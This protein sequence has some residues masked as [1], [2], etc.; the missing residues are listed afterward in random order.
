MSSQQ[1][2]QPP[3]NAP[4]IPSLTNNETFS[5][6]PKNNNEPHFANRV[7]GFISNLLRPTPT[8]TTSSSVSSAP[9]RTFAN[10]LELE[11]A[12]EEEEEEQITLPGTHSAN[13]F[14]PFDEST[15]VH[16]QP[17]ASIQRTASTINAGEVKV[18][19]SKEQL[20]RAHKY[21]SKAHRKTAE[22]SKWAD[23]DFVEL[24]QKLSGVVNAQQQN[25]KPIPSKTSVARL[26]HMEL[27]DLDQTEQVSMAA[28]STSPI[29]KVKSMPK[30][31]SFAQVPVETNVEAVSVPES[32]VRAPTHAMEEKEQQES[33][34][35][36]IQNAVFQEPSA[37]YHN[38]QN[39][40]SDVHEEISIP[41]VDA[42]GKETIKK[43]NKEKCYKIAS[44][45]IED[46]IKN[47][48]FR[49]K[50]DPSSLK[51]LKFLR[52]PL[53]RALNIVVI[54]VLFSLAMFE[55]PGHAIWL[56]FG[57]THVVEMMCLIYILI[58]I[59][60]RYKA[61]AFKF[62]STQNVDIIVRVVVIAAT[63]VDIIVN[64]IS[65][66]RMIRFTR[67]LRTLFLI[68]ESKNVLG[69]Y[70]YMLIVTRKMF[71]IV[72]LLL[73]LV[74]LYTALGRILFQDIP[75][76]PYFG[77]TTF[78]DSYLHMLTLLN[79]FNYP[80]I[81]IPAA[82]V[83]KFYTIYFMFFVAVGLYFVYNLS[84]AIVYNFYKISAQK[85]AVISWRNK[86]TC[87]LAAFTVLDFEKRGFID[88][89]QFQNLFRYLKPTAKYGEAIAF[90]SL[91]DQDNDGY[92]SAI[93][94]L[95][96]C[97][98]LEVVI[99]EDSTTKYRYKILQKLK[100]PLFP[101]IKQFLD[102]AIY[103]VISGSCCVF[104]IM[105]N[106]FVIMQDES[107]LSTLAQVIFHVL[108]TLLIFVFVTDAALNILGIGLG[109]YL[110]S[111]WLRLDFSI[112]VIQVIV[113]VVL[114][115]ILI[116]VLPNIWTTSHTYLRIIIFLRMIVV[117]RLFV[118]SK[119][120]RI[121]M[122]TFMRIFMLV[123]FFFVILFIQMYFFAIIGMELFAD[124]IQRGDP[125]LAGSAYDVG[126]F[127]DIIVFDDIVTSYITLFQLMANNW[128]VTARA[129]IAVTNQWAVIYFVAYHIITVT[130]MLNLLLAFIVEAFV[131]KWDERVREIAEEVVQQKMLENNWTAKK[132][133]KIVTNVM[134]F[135]SNQLY[136]TSALENDFTFVKFIMEQKSNV[137]HTVALPEEEE[138]A[139]EEPSAAKEEERSDAVEQAINV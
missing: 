17:N 117:F 5:K 19:S 62:F 71:E 36:K 84:L 65:L 49:H 13:V 131:Y 77:G 124:T 108:D 50:F 33:L 44:L 21:F 119:R 111:P 88:L 96:L 85:E 132:K 31:K 75:D 123:A 138:G 122:T 121:L 136:K 93:D 32:D 47:R 2:P 14:D 133:G 103:R 109:K 110:K 29:S 98:V 8:T 106:V 126:D 118:I 46:A 112:I 81:M 61:S 38:M 114:E 6:T 115:F 107:Q 113:K 82:K 58:E 101:V 41:V 68:G 52:N 43:P 64:L 42:E 137:E 79:T 16:I 134:D 51:I 95:K 15:A 100:Q 11:E 9:K 127:Y 59:L 67:I 66:G 87:L 34:L 56:P 135:A 54:F 97:D 73:L 7:Q 12:K 53:L 27:S 69:S 94:F 104:A 25:M 130:I 24:D 40:L 70:K 45:Y 102:S 63:T 99:S 30:I 55:H 23:F 92:V 129:Y 89:E 72:I 39:I 3:S 74:A 78:F 76:D 20:L 28:A 35:D 83:S 57:V 128:H 105:L 26:S 22:T 18:A 116:L 37:E 120:L 80:D 1:D 86:R 90:F 4:S 48:N 10:L 60:L 91:A 125:R 139:V